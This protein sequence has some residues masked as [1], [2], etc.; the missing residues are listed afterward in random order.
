MILRYVTHRD[1]AEISTIF[2]KHESD[3]DGGSQKASF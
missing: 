3:P 2:T 1:E